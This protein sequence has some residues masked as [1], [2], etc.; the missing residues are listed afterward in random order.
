MRRIDPPVHCVRP[1]LTLC[2]SRIEDPDLRS[3][4]ESVA[5]ILEAGEAEYRAQA[6]SNT[7]YLQSAA[8]HVGTLTNEEMESLYDQRL[9][10]KGHPAREVYDSLR[11][12]A[13]FN[14]CP[15]CGHR[16]VATLDHYLP[17]SSRPLFAIT[18]VN[19]V[20]SCSDCNKAKLAAVAPDPGSQTFHPYFDSFDDGVWLGARIIEESPPAIVFSVISPA[21]WPEVKYQRAKAHFTMLGLAEL[22]G[23][24]AAQ[25]LAQISLSLRELSEKCGP[26]EVRAHLE[27]QSRSRAALG[28]NTW[29]AAM[30]RA[31][32]Q[33]EWFWRGGHTMIQT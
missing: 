26:D 20:P 21:G 3:R 4:A 29:Q 17:K 14:L 32:L 22:Y 28:P 13:K 33:S 16:Q 2:V 15:L 9:S 12:A 7:L 5:D 23:S 1:T 8:T 11:A 27:V 25:E 30:Y 24:N 31:L 19:L 18:P 10:K 6:A